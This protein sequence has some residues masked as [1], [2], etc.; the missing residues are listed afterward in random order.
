MNKGVH[1][2][3]L[4]GN[5]VCFVTPYSASTKNIPNRTLTRAGRYGGVRPKEKPF[6]VDLNLDG[7]NEATL[8]GAQT[9]TPFNGSGDWVVTKP[10]HWLFKG[11]GMKKGDK[12]S[13]LV[14]WEFHGEP[15]S[16]PGLEVVAEGPTYTG[17]DVESHYTSTIYPGPKGNLVF[18]ASTIFWAQG[19]AQPPGHMPP[20]SHHGRPQGPDER[21]Q[22][23]TKNLFEKFLENT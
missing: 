20:I 6:M 4:S 2:A 22:K 17:G 21:V 7:P 13:G 12:I 19:L 10:E 1:A 3:F 15:A 14:G 9:V 8:I 23:I 18:N 11:T 5:S 16:I